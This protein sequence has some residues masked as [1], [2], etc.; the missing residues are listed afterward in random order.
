MA[1]SNCLRILPVNPALTLHETTAMPQLAQV[2]L[3]VND[4]TILIR[5]VDEN[6]ADFLDLSLHRTNLRL[7]HTYIAL[8]SRE[9]VETAD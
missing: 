2:F 8:D 9:R 5:L 1:S 3:K 6:F 4:P 7:Q